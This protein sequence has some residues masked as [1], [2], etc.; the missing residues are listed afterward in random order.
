MAGH[1]GAEK[2]K[3]RIQEEFFWTGV[4]ANV[5][6]F[7]ASCDICQRTVPKGRVPH[8]SLGQSPVI[9]IPFKRVAIDIV[10]PIR[11]PSGQGNRYILTLVDCATRYPEAVAL[12]GIET[13]RV[14]EALVEMLSRFG[15]PREILSDRGSNFTSELMKEVARLLSVRQLHTTPYHPMAN[16]MV[17]KFNGTLKTMLK[18]MCAEKPKNWDRF[19]GPLLFAYR[20]VPQASLGFSPFELLYGRHVRGPLAILKE[21]WTNQELD[22]ELKTTYQYVL[23]L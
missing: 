22:D 12:P 2:T 18:R 6:R 10:A 13:E 3:D 5:K 11:P 8:V 19:L 20:E 23:D 21:V 7:V 9:D 14:T 16:G 1:L 15:V 4:T 17:E